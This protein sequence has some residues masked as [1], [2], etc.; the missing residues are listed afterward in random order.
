MK[1]YK[2]TV[3]YL[4]DMV[5]VFY[6]TGFMQAIC[7]GFAFAIN[8]GWDNR[9]KYITDINGTTIENIAYPTYTF[10]KLKRIG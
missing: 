10:S 6:C 9:I 8:K 7:L 3:Y 2:H 1:K 5:Q 4:N